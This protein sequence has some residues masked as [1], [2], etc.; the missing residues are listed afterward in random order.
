MTASQLVIANPNDLNETG[1]LMCGPNDTCP[2]RRG[3]IFVRVY[4]VN[5][6]GKS[7]VY[8]ASL[9]GVDGAGDVAVLKIDFTLPWNKDK[10]LPELKKVR[11]LE[12]GK[13]R[14]YEIGKPVYSIGNAFCSDPQ[15][16]ACGC[17]RDNRYANPLQAAFEAITTDLAI[18]K[19]FSGSPLLDEYGKVI[20][21]ATFQLDGDN[22]FTTLFNITTLNSYAGGPSQQFAE[23]IVKTL[24]E[25]DKG[26]ITKKVE[27]CESDL[28]NFFRYVKGFLGA[29]FVASSPCDSLFLDLLAN[30]TPPCEFGDIG[31]KE[32]R[33]YAVVDF[34][35]GAN[36]TSPLADAGIVIGDLILSLGKINLGNFDSLVGPSSVTW[37]LL[38]GDRVEVQY[39]TISDCYATCHTVTIVLDDFPCIYDY[40][41]SE[42]GAGSNPAPQSLAVRAKTKQPKKSQKEEIKETTATGVTGATGSS[43]PITKSDVPASEQEKRKHNVV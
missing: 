1:D 15:S 5:G 21:I 29:E 10:C 19:G 4:N 40:P 32:A 24:I 39:R 22:G 31:F 28:G 3:R 14:C 35:V 36:G 7:F 13:S 43:A 8:E 26:C 2:I 25:A 37:N 23:C 30:A 17:V 16:F 42:G 38:P 27:L 18:G 34:V 12:W 33:G 9:V 11:F 20:G 6:C 41:F